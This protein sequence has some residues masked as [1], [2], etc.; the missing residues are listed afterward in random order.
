M[1]SLNKNLRRGYTMKYIISVEK[2]FK[3]TVLGFG[4][5]KLLI[6]MTTAILI[7]M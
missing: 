6:I 3:V 4:A 1:L 7:M 2:D 5:M